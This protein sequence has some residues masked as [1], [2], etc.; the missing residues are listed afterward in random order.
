M[1]KGGG[2]TDEV[3]RQP[4]ALASYQGLRLYP[5]PQPTPSI[6]TEEEK[7]GSVISAH[8][9]RFYVGFLK[10]SIY[11]KLRAVFGAEN[12]ETKGQ[13]SGD[14][15]FFFFETCIHPFCRLVSLDHFSRKASRYT[16][17]K[18]GTVSASAGCEFEPTSLPGWRP[19]LGCQAAIPRARTPSPAP[20]PARA[21]R[22]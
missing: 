1:Y 22:Q 20:A 5:L 6:T 14:L 15:F 2:G 10:P 19:G 7:T 8:C 13:V 4:R 18:V 12:Q 16:A 21:H 11:R 17:V 3:L 9:L